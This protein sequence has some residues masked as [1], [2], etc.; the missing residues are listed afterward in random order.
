MAD[1]KG[2]DLTALTQMDGDDITIVVDTSGTPTTKKQTATAKRAE[3]ETL[4]NK[5]M[6][7]DSNTFS[8]LVIGA[9]V[10]GASTALT[11][12]AAITYNAD[13]ADGT[14]AY[15]T[16]INQ[17]LISGASPTFTLTN[18]TGLPSIIAA[19]E[20]SD[21]T[22][23][24]L[25]AISATGEVAPKTGT[26]LTFNSS[27]GE[28]AATIFSGAG[29]SLT[30]TAASLT[31]GATT[32][33]EPGADVTDETN[34][35]AALD[36]ATT[37]EATPLAADKILMLDNSDSDNLKHATFSDFATAAQGAT[38]DSALQSADIN[39]LAE[40]NAIVADATLVSNAITDVTGDNLSALAD[41]TITGPVSA[42]IIQWSGSAWIDRTLAE[43]GIVANTGNETI[44]GVKTFS[45]DPIVPEEVYGAGWNGSL[46]P[47]TK[48]ALYDKIEALA[49]GGTPEGTA[50]LSGG[51][52][53]DGY[54]LTADGAGGAAWE[55]GGAG[56]VVKVDT[57]VNDQVG[58]WTG[59]GSIEGS[60]N[61]TFASGTGTLSAT[62]F[63]GAG[64]SLTGTAAS[65]TAGAVS[66]IT[67][68]AP[69]TATTQAAQPNITSL[70]T[71]TVLTVDD[72]TIN[73]NTISSAG[74]STLAINPLAGQAITFD[75]TV[76][77]DAGVIAGATSITSTAFVGALTGNADTVTTITGL[78]PDTATTQAV[79]GAITTASALTTVGALDAGSITSGFT[80]ID[81]GSGAMSCGTLTTT[82]N[83][84]LGHASANTLSASGGVLSVESSEVLMI[85][86]DATLTAGF[87]GTKHDIGELNAETY[88]VTSVGGNY[89]TCN[90]GEGQTDLDPMVADGTVIIEVTND[91]EATL[92]FTTNSF[93]IT[94]GDDMTSTSGESFLLYCCTVNSESH[95]HIK[96]MQ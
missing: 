66:T 88:V 74:A 62:V 49:V 11:D 14:G 27:T 69:D 16:A 70:G 17:S 78:A 33:V 1:T 50:I 31:V 91:A 53:T 82:G 32:G 35:K 48:N 59:D 72:I 15:V 47:A 87:A 20:S 92:A 83:I 55:S 51:P 79:Q 4:T 10:S 43:A 61:L 84:E 34:V 85:D 68:L 57:P 73:G 5:I 93:T 28:L 81:I 38:A 67:G 80:S 46:E 29:T 94:D 2:T 26:N 21:P 30:G 22:C 89:K 23:Y 76:T 54:V 7:G 36:G 40:L 71:L 18:A 52:V 58:V 60:T 45:S 13:F 6:D 86:N 96:A 19:D 37:T 44:A 42:D 64:T 95:C 25:F 3:I 90:N 63:S 75:S 41:V 56:D 9:E 8:N 39:T 65:L 77:L 24:P 12:T